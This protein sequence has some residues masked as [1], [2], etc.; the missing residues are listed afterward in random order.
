[1]K[2]SRFRTPE[3]LCRGLLGRPRYQ[4]KLER[5]VEN[6]SWRKRRSRK[7]LTDNIEVAHLRLHRVGVD[8]AHVPSLV[9]LLHLAN[10][11]LP[12]LPLRVR[13]RNSMVLGD[14]MVLNRQNGLCVDAQPCHLANGNISGQ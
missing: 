10:P 14:D 6:K 2:E 11:Q 12:D 7:N 1:M 9:G 5:K 4:A 8:L 13:D 3:Q